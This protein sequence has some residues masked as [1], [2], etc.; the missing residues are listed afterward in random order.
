[1]RMD[2]ELRN[3]GDWYDTISAVECSNVA[4]WVAGG[5]PLDEWDVTIRDLMLAGF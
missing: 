2:I 5:W 3:F 4:L 1:M